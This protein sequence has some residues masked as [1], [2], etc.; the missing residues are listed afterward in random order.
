M[1]CDAEKVIAR[2]TPD[3]FRIVGDPETMVLSE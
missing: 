2:Q 3:N 1:G